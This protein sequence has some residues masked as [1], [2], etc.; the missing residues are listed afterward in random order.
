[1]T[2]VVLVTWVL[3]ATVGGYLLCTWIL[4][5]GLRRGG[6]D[7][8][9]RFAPQLILGHA[10]LAAVG[11]GIWVA[12]LVG[13]TSVLAWAALA[14]LVVVAALGVTMF[15]LWLRSGRGRPRGRHAAVPRHAAEDHFPPPAVVAHGLFAVTTLALVLVSALQASGWTAPT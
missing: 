12:Y 11:L 15:G 13:A 9:S 14:D 2:V 4:N 10:A 5:G 3:A 6:G 7:R 8:T 1:M